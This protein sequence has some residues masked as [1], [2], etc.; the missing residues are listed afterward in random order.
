MVF[1]MPATLP[2]K[3]YFEGIL[4]LRNPT[5]ELVEW[6]Y[7]TTAKDDRA[8]IVKDD[9]VPGGVDLKF[10]SQQYLRIL[11]RKLK[12]H[13]SGVL[14]VTATLHTV[15]KTGKALYRVTVLFRLLPFKSGNIIKY[16]GNPYRVL[17]IGETK[18]QLQ[19]PHSGKKQWI[20]LADLEKS[21]VLSEA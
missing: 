14:K 9:P 19:D 1:C 2:H 4:Q 20:A 5:T 16:K 15:S 8:F 18:V 21:A 17:L 3:G 6:V 10:S 11:G 12:E 13:F 7:R